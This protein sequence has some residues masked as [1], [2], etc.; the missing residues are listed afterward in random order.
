MAPASDF[1]QIVTTICCNF[2]DKNELVVGSGQYMFMFKMQKNSFEYS[3]KLIQ[4]V[5]MR[6]PLRC[7]RWSWTD[8][9]TLKPYYNEIK[10]SQKHNI[11]IA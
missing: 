9:N 8:R 3:L 7:I 4:Y 5:R 6:A 2:R 10:E 11:A 1:P